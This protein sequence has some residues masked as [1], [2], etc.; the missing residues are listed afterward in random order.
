M[1]AREE[2]FERRTEFVFPRRISKKN[3]LA[4]RRESTLE[5]TFDVK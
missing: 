1:E 3:E 4:Y 5:E 2:S